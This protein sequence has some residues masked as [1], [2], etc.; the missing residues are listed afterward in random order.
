LTH[1]SL[2]GDAWGG[3]TALPVP[4]APPCRSRPPRG[5]QIGALLRPHL[6]PPPL[7]RKFPR[8]T[9][10]S[11]FCGIFKKK[12]LIAR[13]RR[14]KSFQNNLSFIYDLFIV[15]IYLFFIFIIIIIIYLFIRSVAA[16]DCDDRDASVAFK[17]SKPQMA[18][19]H[20]MASR[21][22]RRARLWL[23]HFNLEKCQRFL[24]LLF[25]RNL[26]KLNFDKFDDALDLKGI[27]MCVNLSVLRSHALVAADP[28][29]LEGK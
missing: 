23:C 14:K 26:S 29:I 25:F 18:S 10:Y 2:P 16:A 20:R 28:P 21:M 27:I 24:F 9:R 13:L 11:S 3:A 1:L 7:S 4:A 12:P 15:I 6:G 8:F 17:A 5:P 19:A 22:P